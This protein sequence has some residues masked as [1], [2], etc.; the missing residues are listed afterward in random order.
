MYVPR[1]L[2]EGV[3]CVVVG[4]DGLYPVTNERKFQIIELSRMFEK[5][6]YTWIVVESY[7]ERVT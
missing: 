1:L 3:I 6:R 7:L 4:E 2:G 5:E